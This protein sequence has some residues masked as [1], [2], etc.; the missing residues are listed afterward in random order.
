MLFAFTLKRVFLFICGIVALIAAL[1]AAGF[2]YY[3]SRPAEQGAP[4]HVFFVVQGSTLNRVAQRL[5]KKGI[6]PSKKALLIWASICGFDRNIKAGDYML[7][8]SMPP[9]KILD[10]LNKGLVLT[11]S[12]TIPEGYTRQQVAAILEQK[13]L[14]EKDKFLALTGDPDIARAY[15]LPGPDL[16]GYLYP[17]T[18]QFSRGLPPKAIVDVMVGHFMEVVSP[19]RKRM[20][21]LGLP[22]EQ[23][24]ILASI[25]EKET[26]CEEERPLIAS[27][28]LNRLKNNMR[29]DSD[30][31]V[32]YGIKDFNGNLT[33]NDLITPTP[34]NTYV[35]QGLPPGAIANPGAGSLKAVLY[36]A[37]TSYLYFV[38]KNNGSHYFSETIE[39]HKQAVKQYQ[40]E[41][42]G[43][44]NHKGKKG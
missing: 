18:Y 39:E 5:E 38:S 33:K 42:Q 9:L 31:T 43:K 7:N 14:A 20:N 23:T 6:I 41:G 4:D 16:E 24:V 30:P 17:D 19:L 44:K 26:G 8:A 35:V 22:I 15:G 29:L 40:I 28:F 1:L 3:L 27:V 32:I 21:E 13:G 34:Y 36:P 25:V 37:Q 2:E 10:I 11:Y 12:V